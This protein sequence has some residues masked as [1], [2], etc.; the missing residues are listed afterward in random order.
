MAQAGRFLLRKQRSTEGISL[1]E[2]EAWRPSSPVRSA[3][4][5]RRA[6]VQSGQYQDRLGDRFLLISNNPQ[7][8]PTLGQIPADIVAVEKETE[9]LLSDIYGVGCQ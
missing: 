1:L 9:G 5:C 7:P 6:P 4:L 2:E 8:L 3:A